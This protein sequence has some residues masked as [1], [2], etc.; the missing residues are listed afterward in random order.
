M[1]YLLDLPGADRWSGP[2][3]D[4][5]VQDVGGEADVGVQLTAHALGQ[6]HID[7]SSRSA[8]GWLGNVTA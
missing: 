5:L 4:V 8:S 6:L 7:L 2:S 3:G 1:S